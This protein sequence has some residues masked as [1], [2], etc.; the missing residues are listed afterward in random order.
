M[1]LAEPVKI[2][3]RLMPWTLTFIWC[4]AITNNTIGCYFKA[5]ASLLDALEE[6]LKSLEGKKGQGIVVPPPK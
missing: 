3:K 2:T 6:H 4:Y 1:R 5:P